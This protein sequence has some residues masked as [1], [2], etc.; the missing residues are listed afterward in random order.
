MPDDRS[1]LDIVTGVRAPLQRVTAVPTS[2]DWPITASLRAV[3]VSPST[4]VTVCTGVAILGLCAAIYGTSGSLNDKRIAGIARDVRE[5]AAPAGAAPQ[6]NPNPAIE[7]SAQAAARVD[8]SLP[9]SLPAP[10]SASAERSPAFVAALAPIGLPLGD[11]QITSDLSL[12]R[13]DSIVHT[14][15]PLATL[16]A[17]IGARDA[18]ERLNRLG[19]AYD[20]LSAERDRL[21]ERVNELEQAL[22]LL[23]TPAPPPQAA[24]AP[25][26]V[27]GAGAPKTGVAVVAFPSAETAG[28]SGEQ[29][30]PV[31]KNF[32]TPGTVPNYFTDESGAVL[33]NH[34]AAPTR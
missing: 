5:H 3:A 8:V 22:S 7:P 26:S 1:F 25:D 2:D 19:A 27:I 23:Q 30:R 10:Q 16:W 20:E 32:T 15:G 33:G 6:Q 34:A 29:P 18:E 21:R 31:L 24:K 17:R 14:E 11:P 28:A 13:G 4:A 12:L 9:P